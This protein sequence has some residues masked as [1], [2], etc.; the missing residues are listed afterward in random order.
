MSVSAPK[1]RIR[2]DLPWHLKIVFALLGLLLMVAIAYFV[3][4]TEVANL[5]A[6]SAAGSATGSSE[7]Q[8]QMLELTEQLRQVSDERD[9][10]SSIVNGAE[11]QRNIERAAQNQLLSQMKTLETENAKLKEDLAFFD[12]LLPTNIGVQGVTIQRLK[13]ELVAPNQVRYRMLVMQGQRG[14]G[15]FVGNLQLSV[16][17]QLQGQSQVKVISFPEAGDADSVRFRL[18]FKYYQR[19][20]GDLNLPPGM[21]IKTVQARVLEKGQLRAQQA[22][23]L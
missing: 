5:A 21:T 22:I 10:Y 16:T 18:A 12:S 6:N 1:M 7:N 20:E 15:E 23:N 4:N 9:H 17:V 2:S 8:Q 14:A 3:Y 19:L 11:S 13:A